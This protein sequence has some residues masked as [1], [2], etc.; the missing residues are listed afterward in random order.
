MMNERF[1][2]AIAAIRQ[3]LI[4]ERGEQ[5]PELPT[6]RRL[7]RPVVPGARADDHHSNGPYQGMGLV[8]AALAH[9]EAA[10][11]GPIPNVTLARAL[12]AGGLEHKSKSFPNTL[13]S[14]LRRHGMI[15]GDLLKVAGQGWMLAPSDHAEF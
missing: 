5:Q 4:L 15:K 14:V 2:A 11:G 8:G 12:E 10:G 9:L 3:V 7:P 13:N 1:D 6:L